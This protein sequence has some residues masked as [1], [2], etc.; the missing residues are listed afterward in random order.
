[1][2]GEVSELKYGLLSSV[3]ILRDKENRKRQSCRCIGF[4]VITHTKHNWVKSLSEGIMLHLRQFNNDHVEEDYHTDSS[5]D[6]GEN[7][8]ELDEIESLDVAGV[9]T[10]I[11]ECESC[12]ES[13]STPA[14]FIVHIE[15]IHKV[16][17]VTF[18]R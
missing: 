12:G 17:A 15:N 1:M 16:A 2:E 3:Y 9:D 10:K 11:H 6:G 14:D 4:C 7:V 8:E 13:F 18:L 5:A